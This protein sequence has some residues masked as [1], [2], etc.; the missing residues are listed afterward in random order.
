MLCI[1]VSSWWVGRFVPCG[2]DRHAVR[3]IGTAAFSTATGQVLNSGIRDVGSS[4]SLVSALT[5]AAPPQW[6]GTNTVSG[7][8]PGSSRASSTAL[9]RGVHSRTGS[10]SAMPC[11]RASS[12]CSSTYGRGTAAASVG[13]RRVCVPDWYWRGPGRW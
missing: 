8:M 1:G 6:N 5:Q 12:G 10:P 11:R 2:R 7:R 3:S 4:A 9:P 13:L